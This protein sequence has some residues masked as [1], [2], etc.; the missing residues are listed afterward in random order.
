MFRG[1]PGIPLINFVGPGIISGTTFDHGT[2]DVPVRRR[3]RLYIELEGQLVRE[4]FSDATTGAF[5][6]RGLT[7]TRAFTIVAYDH[8]G[9]WRMEAWNGVFAV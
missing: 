7:T 5:S 4:V 3:V 1:V 9:T 6:F 2:P 8:T